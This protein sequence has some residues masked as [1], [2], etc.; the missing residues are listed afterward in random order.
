MESNKIIER[1]A[2]PHFKGNKAFDE[3]EEDN[4]ES[5]ED[6]LEFDAF[7]L[8]F[9]MRCFSSRT[10]AADYFGLNH[11]SIKRYEDRTIKRV[12]PGYLAGL[13][14]LFSSNERIGAD[15]LEDVRTVL[16]QEINNV[17]KY[18]PWYRGEKL[19]FEWA[20]LVECAENYLFQ[21]KAGPAGTAKWP[22]AIEE[23]EVIPDATPPIAL[24]PAPVTFKPGRMKIIIGVVALVVVLG[25]GLLLF[26][27][28]SGQATPVSGN[29]NQPMR[30]MVVDGLQISSMAIQNDGR[31][32]TATF[33][34][35]NLG[36]QT[37]TF[38][39]L[40]VATRGPDSCSQNWGGVQADFPRIISVTLPPGGDF[41]YRQARS[42]EL[43]GLYFAEPTFQDSNGNWTGIWPWNRVGFSVADAS[44]GS[45]P[46]SNCLVEAGGL[47]LSSDTVKTGQII[48]A[49]LKVRNNTN[50]PITFKQLVVVARSLDSNRADDP[51]IFFPGVADI[52]LLPGQ[53]YEYRQSRSFNQAGEYFTQVS[54]QNAAG[55]W[56][57]VWPYPRL[58][59]RVLENGG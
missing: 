11:T 26:F 56:V 35:R 5:I 9:R 8:D 38:K 16:L 48:T 23:V 22:K 6:F 31:Q 13:A 40:T 19:F 50:Q 41:T 7:L 4:E 15:A 49:T 57:G 52:T 32:V 12:P 36:S 10:R 53:E 27:W 42:F 37:V 29:T 59:F 2:I 46:Q 58:K 14:V 17:L 43:P 55:S 30:M 51:A 28:L 47:Q 25:I 1:Y 20:E 18:C 45:I 33:K 34:L 44:N 3:A 39:N 21:N 54:L 24:S